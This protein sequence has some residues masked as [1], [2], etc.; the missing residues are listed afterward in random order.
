MEQQ[1]YNGLK[2]AETK[3]EVN[4]IQRR[5]VPKLD[6]MRLDNESATLG[7]EP[8]VCERTN[9]GV[10]DVDMTF[11]ARAV[12]DK[13]VKTSLYIRLT[14]AGICDSLELTTVV[15]SHQPPLVSCSFPA[16]YQELPAPHLSLA[17]FYYSDNISTT[18][19]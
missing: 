4:D 8:K 12:P 19:L 16:P 3:D 9:L 10:N 1:D 7:V 2:R 15:P 5:L 17:T 13:V 18:P 14:K 6:E 11:L